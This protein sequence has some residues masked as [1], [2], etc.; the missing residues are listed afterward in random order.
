MAIEVGVVMAAMIFMHRMS[1][2]VELET[3][4]SLIEEDEDDFSHKAHSYPQM[5]HA[6]LPEGVEFYQVPWAFVL[7]RIVAFDRRS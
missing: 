2:V 4:S 3:H 1:E 6:F 5:D 7:R